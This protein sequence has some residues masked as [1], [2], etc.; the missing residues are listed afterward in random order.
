MTN[1]RQMLSESVGR[2]LAEQADTETVRGAE[3]V[4]FLPDL[5]EMVAGSGLHLI[6]IPEDKG[7]GGGELADAHAV[8]WQV[9]RNASPIPVAETGLLGGWALA[10]AGLDLPDGIV[11]VVPNNAS[12]G[13]TAERDGSGV[14]LSGAAERVAWASQSERVVVLVDVDGEVLVVSV[15][16]AELTCGG[17]VTLAG[18]PRE[19]VSFDRVSVSSDDVATAPDSVSHDSL[20][21]R[22]ALSR[23]TMMGGAMERAAELGER[24][25]NERHQ[26]GRPISKFQA[27]QQHLVAVR[28]EANRTRMV[29]NSALLAIEEGRSATFEIATAKVVAG[30]STRVLARRAH[31]LH[32]AIGVTFEYDLQLFT[33]RLHAW[34]D[35]Y[36]TA[37]YWAT[38]VAGIVAEVGP[39][40]VWPL[41]TRSIAS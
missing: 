41:I 13:V 2:L 15:P 18:E 10:E 28:E 9:G 23:V 5:W 12:G 25:T 37:R 11:T 36:G 3:G 29:G 4:G 17:E 24:Y 22:G 31:Q 1:E 40:Q 35:E 19:T 38:R 16:T 39:G 26:F 27:V 34:R 30:E 8:L 32:G 7:G 14:K 6:A 21:Q 20:L 33:R